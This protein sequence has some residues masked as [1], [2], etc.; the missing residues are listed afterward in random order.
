M[1]RQAQ[2]IMQRFIFYPCW[3]H[4][5]G[6]EAQGEDHPGEVIFSFHYLLP[7]SIFKPDEVRTACQ[8]WD[9]DE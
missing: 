9:M 1:L 2:S 7:Q 6:E 8:F 5:G 3:R 4:G